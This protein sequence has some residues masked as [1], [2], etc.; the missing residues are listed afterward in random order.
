MLQSGT[1][2]VNAIL[3]PILVIGF[4]TGHPLGVM[5]AGL[6]SSIAAVVRPG[7]ALP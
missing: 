1:V 3:A 5:G 7:R 4:G 2:V 6:A